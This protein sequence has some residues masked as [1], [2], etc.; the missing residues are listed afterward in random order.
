[1]W[2]NSINSQHKLTATANSCVDCKCQALAKLCQSLQLKEAIRTTEKERVRER[3]G[4]GEREKNW[5]I[6]MQKTCWHLA[7][8][9][10]QLTLSAN[11]I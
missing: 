2:F 3:Q 10:Q 11:F 6:S 5:S 1:M 7:N 8:F 4:E 9:T